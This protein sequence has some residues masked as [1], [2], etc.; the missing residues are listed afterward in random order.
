MVGDQQSGVGGGAEGRMSAVRGWRPVSHSEVL[1]ICASSDGGGT[2]MTFKPQPPGSLPAASSFALG[3]FLFI[4][5]SF[6]LLQGS[7][8]HTQYRNTL[9]LLE[10]AIRSQR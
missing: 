6:I 9:P 1:G 8:A 4:R 3:H 2:I 5:G 7:T 10:P